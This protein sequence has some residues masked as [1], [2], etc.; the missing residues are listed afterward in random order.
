MPKIIPFY[1]VLGIFFGVMFMY[2][3]SPKPKIILKEPNLNNCKKM[4]YIDNSGVC[5]K[6]KKKIAK[7]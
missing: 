1:L 5:Y 6:Y 4:V 7:N 3:F 2:I